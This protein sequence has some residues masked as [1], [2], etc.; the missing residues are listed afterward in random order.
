MGRASKMRKEDVRLTQANMYRV[1]SANLPEGSLVKNAVS[2]ATQQALPG[3][4]PTAHGMTW[5]FVPVVA[6]VVRDKLHHFVIETAR[7]VSSSGETTADLLQ[8]RYCMCVVARQCSQQL[9]EALPQAFTADLRGKLFDM[10]SFYCEE[11]QQPGVMPLPTGVRA[12]AGGP[13][14]IESMPAAH[15][16]LAA[17]LQAISVRSCGASS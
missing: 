5:L 16:L 1:L 7:H 11:G 12:G 2:P 13:K 3:L 4:A 6:Q 10:F 9:A 17:C 8:L 14:M 15:G